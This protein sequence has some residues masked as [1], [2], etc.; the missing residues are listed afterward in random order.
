MNTRT[1]ARANYPL[2]TSQ[3]VPRVIP[4]ITARLQT[5]EQTMLHRKHQELQWQQK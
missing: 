4:V 1:R 5:I 2:V 3:S